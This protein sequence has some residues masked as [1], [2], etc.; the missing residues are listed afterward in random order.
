[1]IALPRRRPRKRSRAWSKTK[2]RRKGRDHTLAFKAQVA[3]A[4]LKGDKTL[5]ELTQQFDVHP[6]QI[7]DLKTQL[8]ERAAQA[9]GETGAK[10]PGEPELKT[11]GL[12]NNWPIRSL[13]LRG[14]R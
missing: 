6:D 14:T 9:F 3:I 7:A 11:L 2:A 10:A 13:E 8:M 5:A 4:A 1:M 12:P